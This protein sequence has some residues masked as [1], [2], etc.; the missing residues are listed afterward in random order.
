MREKIKY[1]WKGAL[2][3]L[4]IV[5]VLCVGIGIAVAAWDDTK[6]TSDTLTAAEWNA[7]TADQNT[8]ITDDISVPKN[9]IVNSGVLGFDWADD[10]VSNTLTASNVGG[11]T[12]GE[13]MG[14]C[15]ATD[16]HKGDGGCEAESSLSVALAADAGQVDGIEGAEIFK[17]DGSVAATGICYFNEHIYFGADKTI[18][19]NADDGF[20]YLQGGNNN[21]ARIKLHGQDA[22]NAGYII[23]DVP[24]AAKTGSVTALTIA[25]VTDTP[26]LSFEYALRS[27]A[28]EEKTVAAGVTIDSCLI[29]D[30][31]AADA[32][33]LDGYSAAAFMLLDGTSAMA[34]N[35]D[36]N[37]NDI[38][39]VRK[40]KSPTTSNLE[41]YRGA[42][43]ELY[44][45][46]GGV[47]IDNT[48]LV[49]TIEEFTLNA[50]VTFNDPIKIDALKEKSTGAGVTIDSCLIKDGYPYIPN[51]TPSTASE[52]CT[53][54][55]LCY[56]SNYTYVCIATDT[57]ERAA[58]SSW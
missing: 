24:N 40:I 10:E 25:G 45:S 42:A 11:F 44:L 57:W 27:D 52:A 51:H 38:L 48:L 17:K 13:S 53:A 20:I 30:G 16:V 41:F 33:K 54:G 37:E 39:D 18:R 56:D 2:K 7:M 49:D 9:H 3:A 12:L 22:G 32:D 58:L 35:L 23:F 4:V 8:K 21:A 15:A 55:Q 47:I 1:E 6:I 31:K 29:K 14:N 43:R 50:D 19:R 28:I 5:A 26:K 34:G 46:S 36:I